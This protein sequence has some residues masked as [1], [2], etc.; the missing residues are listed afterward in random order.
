[1]N[2][3]ERKEYLTIPMANS[4]RVSPWSFV[5]PLGKDSEKLVPVDL[6]HTGA[7]RSKRAR[8]SKECQDP[9][10]WIFCRAVHNFKIIRDVWVAL[11]D[12]L[13]L[14]S[15]L[16]RCIA[17]KRHVP[18]GRIQV[19]VVDS[20]MDDMEFIFL[21]EELPVFYYV[22]PHLSDRKKRGRR[23]PY[24]IW[25]IALQ[26]MIRTTI[27]DPQ[28]LLAIYLDDV[29][30]AS[31]QPGLLLR[32]MAVIEAFMSNWKVQLNVDKTVCILSTKAR[33]VWPSVFT[34]VD[35][36]LS[37]RLLGVEVGPVLNGHIML[38]RIKNA[39]VCLL[40]VRLL[41]CP[42]HLK[43]RLVASFVCPLLYG[44]CFS[45]VPIDRWNYLGDL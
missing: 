32:C 45:V 8:S 22:S 14:V 12:A 5:L 25:G 23:P 11:D 43:R 6:R 39:I 34:D 3:A 31:S 7:G 35:P 37:A 42:L 28:V 44:V 27:P 19:T 9:N 2:L 41:P 13:V 16:K 30:F 18:V 20:V 38:D 21:I 4:L 24:I 29:S 1:M 10:L 40:R 26:S 15:V 17:D 33:G 36:V